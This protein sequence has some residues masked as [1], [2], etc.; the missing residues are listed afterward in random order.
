MIKSKIEIQ[1]EEIKQRDSEIGAF[2]E[3]FDDC[4]EQ[5]VASSERFKVTEDARPLE[6]M[7]IAIKDNILIK[8]KIASSASKMLANYR[9]T[10]D[11]TAIVRLRAAGAIFIGRT[12]MD[13]FAMGSSTENSAFQK[14]RN[15][16]NL[17]RVP[18]GSSGGSAAAV[19]AGF[20]DAALGSDTAGSVRQPASFCGVIGL[21]PTYGAVSRYGLMPLT[22]SIDQIGPIA[23]RVEDVEKIFNVIRGADPLDSTSVTPPSPPPIPAELVVGVL[24]GLIGEGVSEEVKSNFEASKAKLAE[25]GIK[26]VSINLPS[27]EYT[28]AAYYILTP[29]EVSSNLARLDGLRYGYHKEGETLLE[30]YERSRAIGFGPEVR[31]RILVGTYVLSAGYYDA[32]YRRAVSVRRQIAADFARAFTVVDAIML[33]TAPTTAFRLGEKLDDPLQMYLA[34]IFTAPANL[35]G[36]PAISIPSGKDKEG[37]PFGLQFMAAPHREDILFELSR[38]YGAV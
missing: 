27:L 19:A 13:E 26:L 24:E 35:A 20:A 11:A 4:L 37:L 5:A 30:E 2:L 16:H 1:L 12:N 17:E 33:P 23:R 34:D 32:Y 6:G 21:K 9:A 31:R 38:V 22:S 14:T 8:G 25:K 36:I 10:Y 15:P 28:L 3:V 7:T 29:A 18:G